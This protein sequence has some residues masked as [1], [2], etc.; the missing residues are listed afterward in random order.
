MPKTIWKSNKKV[1]LIF[2]S[3]SLIYLTTLIL[4][5]WSKASLPLCRLDLSKSLNSILN[6]EPLSHAHVGISLQTLAS[7]DSLFELNSDSYFT[8]AS[9]AK[10]FTTAAAL[11][12]LG[13]NF[14][15]S[16]DFFFDGRNLIVVGGGDPGLSTA[17]LMTAAT[18]LRQSGITKINKLMILLEDNLSH[19]ANTW[20]WGDLVFDYAALPGTINF[21]Q[22]AFGLTLTPTKVGQLV[23]L[24]F[25]DPRLAAFLQINNMVRSERD[26]GSVEVIGNLKSNSI[27][28]RGSINQ[29]ITLGL[30]IPL[31]EDYFLDS[32]A[33]ILKETGISVAK[34]SK[35]DTMPV[36]Y[37]K[38]A[39]FH[40]PPLS[41][42]IKT[43]NQDSNNFYA[44][45]LFNLLKSKSGSIKE[46]LRIKADSF[47][48]IDG[49]GLSR[50]DLASPRSIVETLRMVAESKQS[51][52]YKNSLALAGQSGTLRNRFKGT[53]IEGKLWAKSGTLTGVSAL[54]GYLNPP[55]Y[56]PLVFS[57][58]VNQS[59]SPNLRQTIDEIIQL[60]SQLSPC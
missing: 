22:N 39:Q 7:K 17:N 47:F 59:P 58:L 49:S 51:A 41:E 2:L 32:F 44:E 35:T 43:I 26:N 60:F 25:S 46:S 29:P 30:T 15:F 11:R 57:I 42:I 23:D 12:F 48:L 45:A 16:T 3:L 52:I 50:E 33:Q 14:T 31:I 10:I 8:P 55:N 34:V 13:E 38:I 27:E 1:N 9:N 24:S 54:S 53:A 40:S 28:L 20:Q 21:N 56:Q 18:M 37:H 5:Q 6:K 36:G 19:S 4:P